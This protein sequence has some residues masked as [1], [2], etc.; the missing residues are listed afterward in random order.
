[1]LMEK[2]EPIKNSQ[3]ILGT[4]MGGLAGYIHIIMSTQFDTLTKED[5][6][7]N[8]KSLVTHSKM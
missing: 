3:L 4:P 1:M 8:N 2:I 5:L 7:I 6:V